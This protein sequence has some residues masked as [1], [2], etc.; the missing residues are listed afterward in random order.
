MIVFSFPELI[1]IALILALLVGYLLRAWPTWAA[2][3]CAFLLAAIALWTWRSYG[4]GSLLQVPLLPVGVSLTARFTQFN[5]VFFLQQSNLPMVVVTLLITAAAL[6]FSV[7]APQGA[8]FI[9]LSL[10]TAGGYVA[11]ALLHTAPLE[12][13]LLI[14][15]AL[16]IMATLNVFLL[17][18]D[19]FGRTGGALRSLLGPILAFPFFLPV[20]WYIEQIPLNPQNNENFLVAGWLLAVG[21]LLLLA[22]AP[23]HNGQPAAAQHA[24]PLALALQTLLYQL[25]VLALLSRTLARFSF[26][27][28]LTPLS[29]WL[30]VGGITTAIWGGLAAAGTNHP[31]RLWGYALLHDRGL[32]LLLLAL[33]GPQSWPLVIFLFTLRAMSA[34]SA[35]AGLA[36][37]RQAVGSLDIPEQ[38][39][40]IGGRWPW[41]TSLFLLGSLGL[42]GF[43]LSVGF[44][45]HWAALQTIADSDWRVATVVLLASGGV[46]FGFVRL[47]RLLFGPLLN[48]Y[49]PQERTAS[50]VVAAA[51]IL[52]SLALAFVPQLLA[53]P[54]NWVLSAFQ[55]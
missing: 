49:L 1:G 20:A 33:P 9:P 2:T 34:L 8:L 31:G 55:R 48:R 27:L 25:A 15:L 4:V 45:G 40:G 26:A 41:S 43:P 47:V 51:V 52:V 32:I 17:Q 30:T 28:D 12:P 21:L 54:V 10:I 19:R 6:G 29:L 22:P 14:P 18:G 35:A 36:Q 53:G 7:L 50:G 39:R 24:P 46:V 16:A 38:L 5:F 3:F 37:L 11:M 42:A 44:T 23:L 13:V